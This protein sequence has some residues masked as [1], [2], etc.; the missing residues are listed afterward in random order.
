[1][2]NSLEIAK[3]LA[4]FSIIF[5]FLYAIYY[6]I[7]KFGWKP[8]FK[9]GKNI[10]IIDTLFLSKNRY[11][12][13]VRVRNF[14]FLLGIDEHGIK[15]IKEWQEDIEELKATSKIVVKKVENEKKRL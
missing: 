10:E 2:H 13:L 3:F 11:L 5:I 6:F 15:K 12:H 14:I 8:S 9:S 4:S 7:K 1:M